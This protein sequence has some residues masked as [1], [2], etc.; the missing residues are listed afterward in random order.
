MRNKVA[1]MRISHSITCWPRISQ[2]KWNKISISMFHSEAETGFQQSQPY[3]DLGMV[4]LTWANSQA[5]QNTLAGNILTRIHNMHGFCVRV[6]RA[7]LIGTFKP[8][9]L[10]S[11]CS[12]NTI[13]LSTLSARTDF[14]SEPF[15]YQDWGSEF[16]FRAHLLCAVSWTASLL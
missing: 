12:M 7:N 9:P 10:V 14:D 1:T 6:V 5:P 2:I 11:P 15:Q 3:W 8:V 4:Y 16:P 13:F